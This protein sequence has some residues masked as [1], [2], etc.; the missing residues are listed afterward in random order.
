MVAL[1]RIN[2]PANNPYPT[3]STVCIKPRPSKQHTRW[4]QANLLRPMQL[5]TTRPLATP[6]TRR[7]TR[8]TRYVMIALRSI[9]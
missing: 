5:L 1:P 9:W 6:C 2:L 7:S 8:V 4:K 3:A